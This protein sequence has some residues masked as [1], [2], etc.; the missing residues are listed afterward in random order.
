MKQD[1][2]YTLITGASMGIGRAFAIECAKRGMNLALVSLPESGL[3]KVIQYIKKHFSVDIKSLSIDLTENEAPRKIFNWTQKENLKV[4][5]LINNAGKGHLGN[6][7]D[8]SYKFYENLIRLNIE[9]VVLL[10]RLFLPEMKKMEQAYIM[11]LGS[12]ASYYPMPYKII[13]AGSKMFVYSFSRALREELKKTNVHV[14]ILCPGPIITSQ[15]VITRIRHGGFWGKASSMKA[16]KV[17]HI[18][19]DNLLKKKTVIIPGK[20]NKVFIFMNK[21]LSTNFKQRIISKRFNVEN[22]NGSDSSIAEERKE[23]KI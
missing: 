23:I 14:S 4:N 16:Q 1:S 3:E 19:I 10:T 15:E 17:A 6:F 18:A 7:L 13:Y 8:Y 9:S 21:L 2:Y 22:K 20:I 11:N 5:M 12:V